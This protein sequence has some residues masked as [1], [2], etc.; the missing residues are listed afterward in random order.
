MPLPLIYDQGLLSLYKHFVAKTMSVADGGGAASEKQ[1]QINN[2]MGLEWGIH[3]NKSR[4]AGIWWLTYE[5]ADQK[6]GQ[7]AKQQRCHEHE[8]L[9][10]AQVLQYDSAGHLVSVCNTN[11]MLST[12]PHCSTYRIGNASFVDEMARWLVILDR[13]TRIKCDIRLVALNVVQHK[14]KKRRAIDDYWRCDT[15]PW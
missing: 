1:I 7:L 10:A 8:Q 15:C 2:S 6:A 4:T 9:L 11:I 12:P 14:R 5:S 3:H 13:M